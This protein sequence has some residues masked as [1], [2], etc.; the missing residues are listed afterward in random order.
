[1]TE[2]GPGESVYPGST[3][4]PIIYFYLFIFDINS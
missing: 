1:M 3:L 4:L 2:P